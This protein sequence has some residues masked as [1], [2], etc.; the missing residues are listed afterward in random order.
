MISE[1]TVCPHCDWNY[2]VPEGVLPQMCPH[3]F[4]ANLSPLVDQEGLTQEHLPYAEPPELY[5]PF[6]LDGEALARGMER[7]AGGIRFAPV[8]MTPQNLKSRLKRIFFPMWLVDV[9]VQA[10]WQA[11]AGFDY[12]VVSHQD[13]FDET[14][15]GWRSHEVKENR[16]RWE[17]RLGRLQRSYQNLVAPALE[18]DAQ[19]KS[20]LGSYNLANPNA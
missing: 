14:R 12:E 2:L 10:T 5:L 20:Q 1:F 15:G 17:P 16:V 19:I 11:E 6:S 8:D 9:D 4:R 18:D 7:F 3:C 13:R